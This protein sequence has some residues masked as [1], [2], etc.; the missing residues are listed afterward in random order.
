MKKGNMRKRLTKELKN[1]K[2][3]TQVEVNGEKIWKKKVTLLIRNGTQLRSFIVRDEEDDA[4]EKATNI[5]MKL[6]KSGMFIG[7]VNKYRLP[8]FD[9]NVIFTV[10]TIEYM[11]CPLA[12]GREG[13]VLDDSFIHNIIKKYHM[14]I[15]E[16]VADKR[17]EIEK[18]LR[19]LLKP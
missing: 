17:L 10:I 15:G 3:F 5:L 8:L 14:R 13:V 1:I 12:M 7:A 2:P 9:D 6:H 4:I 19:N 16:N 18:E 11:V